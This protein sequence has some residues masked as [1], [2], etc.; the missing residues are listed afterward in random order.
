MNKIKIGGIIAHENLASIRLGGV[1]GRV[2]AAAAFLS[3]L[4]DAGVNV[5]F[6][7]HL[8][9]QQGQDQII[10]AVDRNDLQRAFDLACATQ[11]ELCADATSCDVNVA[12]IGIFG[13][14][15]RIRPGIAGTFLRAIS[16]KKIRVHAISTS[17]STCALLIPAEKL[18]DA[19][20]AIRETFEMPSME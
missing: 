14:D 18:G 2:D 15:F 17:I 12:S 20:E 19:T 1:V 10:V 5:Q 16:Q 3:A 4:G 6:L 7:A 11:L 8:Q 9:D 13:P